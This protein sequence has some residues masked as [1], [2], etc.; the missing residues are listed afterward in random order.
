MDEKHLRQFR[1]IIIL[2]GFCGVIKALA[3]DLRTH[4]DSATSAECESWYNA[5]RDIEMAREE[6]AAPIK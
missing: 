1:Q 2:Y 3:D 6:L 4:G 5:A